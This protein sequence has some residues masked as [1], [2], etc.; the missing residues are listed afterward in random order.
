[1]LS[2]YRTLSHSWIMITRS[3]R[4]DAKRT[5]DGIASRD[6]A[7]VKTI[8]RNTETTGEPTKGSTVLSTACLRRSNNVSQVKTSTTVGSD[9]TNWMAE[10]LTHN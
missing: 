9:D 7:G 10:D 2:I 8:L 4:L 3:R 1:M 5:K 6:R